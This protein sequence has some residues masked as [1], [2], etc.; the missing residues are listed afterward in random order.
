MFNNEKVKTTYLVDIIRINTVTSLFGSSLDSLLHD[1]SDVL[2]ALLAV[3]VDI[4]FVPVA[5]FVLK[6]LGT[7]THALFID[8]NPFSTVTIR[9]ESELVVPDRHQLRS[10]CRKDR[11]TWKAPRYRRR[12]SKQPS[13][14]SCGNRH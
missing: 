1:L 10:Q 12:C 2:L 6:S 5:K 7:G 13:F 8:R 14:P 11:L 4:P 3:D 9:V